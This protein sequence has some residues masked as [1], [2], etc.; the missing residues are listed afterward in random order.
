MSTPHYETLLKSGDLVQGRA[1]A[2][3][4]LKRDP[5]DRRALLA[6]AKLAAFEGD[7]A[8][9][10][11]LLARA[12]GGT[13]KDEEDAMLVKAAL[14][15]RKGDP[16]AAGQLYLKLAEDPPRAEALYG[17]GFLLAEAEENEL[18]RK[19]LQKAVDLEPQ[20]AVYHFQLAR[21]QF[22]LGQM[23][24]AFEHLETSL[25]LNPAHIP[26]YVVF[27][28][29]MQAG[30]EL[31][32][33]EDIL[34]QGLKA[35]PEDP[36]LL[37]SL[38]N[39][40][41]AK[42]DWAG[43]AEAAEKLA[44]VQPNHP[45]AISNLARFRMV[46]RRFGDALS[47]CQALAERGMATVESRSVEAMIYEAMNPP[48]LEGAAAAWRA[49]MALDPKEWGAANNLGNLLMRMPELPDAA[50]QAREVLEEGLRRS[51]DRPELQLNLA[52]ACMKL[53][54]KAKAKELAKVLVGRG[55]SLE[56][57]I[58]QQAE[59]LLKHAN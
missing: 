36:Y 8:R 37:Q 6:L 50:K 31:D 7:E 49:A 12:A 38:C 23:K 17:V 39:V 51:P 40:L 28:I 54:D 52:L 24:E 3:A 27:A 22:A 33:A 25:K 13:Q 26:S 34:R 16:Q 41:A 57:S 4:A 53:G 35:F 9:A 14:L 10:E 2:E 43:A 21:V 56:E 11:S 19:A 44:S 42:G 58:R 55:P 5:K 18:A 20:E 45:A 30:G 29:A 59:Q 1:E 48:D 47:L 32:A 15:M 46:Q